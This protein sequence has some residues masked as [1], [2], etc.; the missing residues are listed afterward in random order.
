MFKFELNAAVFLQFQRRLVGVAASDKEATVNFTLDGNTLTTRYQ[1][2]LGSAEVV[3]LFSESLEVISA[4][5]SGSATINV[6]E[7]L[8]I[9]L[10]AFSDPDKFPYTK[11]IEF[12]FQTSILKTHWKVHHSPKKTS[13]VNLAHA[14]QEN[15][16]DL[17][18][19]DKLAENFENYIELSTQS[20][21]ETISYCN[22]FKADATSRGSNGCLFEV[23]GNSLIAVGTNSIVAS[24][25]ECPIKDQNLKDSF[26]IVLDNSI[27]I[28]IKTFTKDLDSI[29]LAASD[30]FL[31]LVSDTRRMCVPLMNV[32]YN[33]KNPQDFFKVNSPFIGTIEPM[34]IASILRTLTHLSRD[35]HNRIQLVFEEGNFSIQTSKNSSDSL[36]CD[37]VSEALIKVNSDLLLTSIKKLQTFSA[38]PVQLF[39]NEKNRRII[40]SSPNKELVFLIQ[41]MKTT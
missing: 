33:I 36:P 31:F 17:S 25:F 26:R 30:K 38:E 1:S 37:L 8:G 13:K 22:L 20:L 40:L 21:H 2:K 28:F 34:P 10:E 35:V 5:N 6:Q 9:K 16:P 23:S 19:F 11:E 15:T 24:K 41:G 18:K 12:Y 27:L 4:E 7:L 14:I 32:K 39:F 3:S 29:K